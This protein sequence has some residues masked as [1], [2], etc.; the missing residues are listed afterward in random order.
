MLSRTALPETRSRITSVDINIHHFLKSNQELHDLLK[1][2]AYI[3][4]NASEGEYFWWSFTHTLYDEQSFDI[5]NCSLA[6]QYTSLD[7]KEQEYDRIE[8]LIEMNRILK[9]W[10]YILLQEIYSLRFAQDR[11]LQDAL[12]LLWF[13][14]VN[15]FSWDIHSALW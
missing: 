11:K 8:A 3:N 10:G 1:Q 4:Y 15:Q 9:P 5:I 14:L 13:E 6:W 7:K 2:P 12:S